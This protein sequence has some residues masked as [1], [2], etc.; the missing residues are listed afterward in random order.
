MK[1][2]GYR[3]D[4]HATW[5]LYRDMADFFIQDIHDP[6]DVPGAI[7]MDTLMN[8]P[9]VDASLAQGILSLVRGA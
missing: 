2:M 5:T 3:P 9:G 1:A 4:S 6:V 7:R 8:A